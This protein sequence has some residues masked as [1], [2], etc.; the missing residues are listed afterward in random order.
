MIP[1]GDNQVLI[2]A[3][4]G[5]IQT[6]WEIQ[7]LIADTKKYLA[8]ANV[9]HIQHIFREGGRVADWVAKFGLTSCSYILWVSIPC[10]SLLSILIE[11]NLGRTLERRA[12]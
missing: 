5:E 7:T 1:E 12:T 8:L 4:K 9:V 10:V 2:K 11:D 3:L 6:P